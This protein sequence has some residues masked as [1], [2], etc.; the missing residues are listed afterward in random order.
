MTNPQEIFQREKELGKLF[1]KK[2]EK[3]NI[4][5]RYNVSSEGL[6]I[7]VGYNKEGDWDIFQGELILSCLIKKFKLDKIGDK[8]RPAILRYK[9]PYWESHKLTVEYNIPC[10]KFDFEVF[11]YDL[12]YQDYNTEYNF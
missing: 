11:F 12:P 8:E 6:V 7:W 4:S 10:P 2:E 1:Q 3:Q 5:K 9:S